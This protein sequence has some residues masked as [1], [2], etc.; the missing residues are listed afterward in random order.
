M[1]ASQA[2]RVDVAAGLGGG[3]ELGNLNKLIDGYVD[4]DAGEVEHLGNGDLHDDDIH[5]GQTRKIPVARGLTHVVLVVVG[6]KDG[7]AE[8]LAGVLLVVFAVVLGSSR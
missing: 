6:I 1:L 8:Q 2:C 5:V 4:G 7:R 3:V